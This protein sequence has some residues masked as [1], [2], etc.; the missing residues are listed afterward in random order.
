MIV[1]YNAN[2]FQTQY[3]TL[4]NDLAKA[5]TALHT[6][7]QKLQDRTQGLIKGGKC[8]TVASITTQCKAILSRPS[9]K[10]IMTYTVQKDSHDIPQLDYNLDQ[11]VIN[12][13]SDTYLGKNIILTDRAK[14]HDEQ[15]I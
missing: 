15:I 2:L 13:R 14:W 1:T 4:Q 6:L 7:S 8:P 11:D 12:Q 9:M 5:I 10:S 3:L